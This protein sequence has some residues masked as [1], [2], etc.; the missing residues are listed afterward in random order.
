M[1]LMKGMNVPAFAIFTTLSG[2]NDAASGL[3]GVAVLS[4]N[5]F[6]PGARQLRPGAGRCRDRLRARA[7]L[8]AH[9]LLPMHLAVAQ[10]AAEQRPATSR[11]V[12]TDSQQSVDSSIQRF[13][14]AKKANATRSANDLGWDCQAAAALAERGAPGA[15]DKLSGIADQML[16]SAVF[17]PTTGKAIGWTSSIAH[18]QCLASTASVTAGDDD[19]EDGKPGKP[20]KRGGG[21]AAARCGGGQTTYAF[22]TGLGIACLARA[23]TILKRPEFADAAKSAFA[24]WDKQRLPNP[25]CKDCIYY[26][27][28]DSDTDETS[29][30]RNMNVFMAFGAAALA[31]AVNDSKAAES[32]RQAMRSEMW[33]TSHGNRG[34][35]SKLDP[36]WAAKPGESDRIENHSASVAL[37]SEQIGQMLHS[38]EIRKHGLQ[39]WRDW[40]NC[41]N[42]RCRKAGCKYWAGDAGQCQA[43]STAAHCAFRKEDP[44]AASQC[45][46]YLSRVPALPN[47]GIWASTLAR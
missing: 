43:T 44:L 26:A 9:L 20:E 17:S 12:P 37:L 42:D 28:S 19:A 22:Q 1:I 4:S 27:T 38:E 32:A 33:E 39:V 30:V 11:G 2:F 45:K 35:L 23:S 6:A 8:L 29:Y 31:Q 15:I 18:P 46:E 14:G 36:R 5:V 41:D 3:A 40:A 34:Y 25:P 47:Y 16:R 10:D 13:L 7:L 21:K 24:Y